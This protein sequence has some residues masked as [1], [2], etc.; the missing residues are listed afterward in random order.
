MHLLLRP[1]SVIPPEQDWPDLLATCL[2]EE[3]IGI[4]DWAQD[5][6]KAPATVSRGFAAAFGVTPSGYRA[7]ARV[8][9]ALRLLVTGTDPLAQIAADCGFSDQAHLCRNVKAVSQYAKSVAAGQIR[10]RPDE[11]CRVTRPATTQVIPGVACHSS[12][13]SCSL[14][15]PSRPKRYPPSPPLLRRRSYDPPSVRCSEA[16]EPPPGQSFNPY[17]P[18]IW[19]PRTCNSRMHPFPAE[20]RGADHRRRRGARKPDRSSVIC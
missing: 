11:N 8:A 12:C 6:G 15:R 10:S 9:R 3:A 17:L 18:A 4:T 7:E 5:A 20:R 1:D 2:R 19:T 13:R 16:R 14:P